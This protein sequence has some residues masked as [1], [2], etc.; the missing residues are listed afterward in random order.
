MVRLS[1]HML[2]LALLVFA[3]GP[4]CA[5]ATATLPLIIAHRGGL[6]EAPENTLMAIRHAVASHADMIWLTVQLSAD[7]VPVLFHDDDL[8]ATTDGHGAVASLPLAAL[9]TLD[10]GYRFKV[11]VAGKI[12][13]PDRGRGVT[14]PT[15][16]EAL[17]AIP[18]GIPVI[19][20]MKALPAPRQAKAVASVLDRLDAWPR[21][22]IYSTSA[23]YQ[24]AFAAYPKA[25]MFETRDATR[26]R[27]LAAALASRCLPPPASGQWAAFE[28]SV[29]LT[30]TEHFTLGNGQ[31][32]TLAHLWTK[33]AMECFESAGPVPIVGIGV[34]TAGDLAA[35]ACLGMTAVLSN[36]P[37]RMVALRDAMV[38]HPPQC[39]P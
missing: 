4:R 14:L 39:P 21:V 38:A 5:N 31:S 33:A 13:T 3:I 30:V 1:H 20:D 2:P 23:T 35:A 18:D 25:R 36:A 28:L 12:T 37:G 10:A 22:R 34:N 24:E 15:L 8:S 11:M 27:L 29:P 26:S 17:Q 9:Q 6:A 19:L 32:T 7:G 16:A